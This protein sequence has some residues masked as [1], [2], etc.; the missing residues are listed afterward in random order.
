MVILHPSWSQGAKQIPKG[1]TLFDEGIG[2]KQESRLSRILNGAVSKK[3][4]TTWHFECDQWSLSKY[5][6]AIKLEPLF[7]F[8]YVALARC[9]YKQ[10]DGAWRG[11]AEEAFRHLKETTAIQSHH[12]FH[13]HAYKDIRKLLDET[14]GTSG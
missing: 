7:P 12:A 14:S 1:T 4:D 10:G 11:Y 5:K 9:L 2:L 13:G 3:D 8:S 6:N